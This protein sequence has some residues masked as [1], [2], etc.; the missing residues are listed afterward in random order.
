MKKFILL[1]L[2]GLLILPR[3]VSAQ[4]QSIFG[5]NQTSWFMHYWAFTPEDAYCKPDSMWIV[6]GQDTLIQNKAFKPLMD[7]FSFQQSPSLSGY[8]SEDTTSGEVWFRGLNDTVTHKIMD[9]RLTVNDSFYVGYGAFGMKA[10]AVDSIYYLNSRKHIQLDFDYPLITNRGNQW[11]K[12]TMIEGVGVNIKG[13]Y[14]D[15]ENAILMNHW[16]DSSLVYTTPYDSVFYCD[17]ITSL[18][19]NRKEMKS[20]ELFPNPMQTTTNISL[21]GISAQ[22]IELYDIRGRKI[23]SFPKTARELDFS[24]VKNGIY[25]IKVTTAKQG[26]LNKKIVVQH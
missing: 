7:Q 9:M 18:Q 22:K 15:L 3:S 1:A 17:T 20:F 24:D 11:A 6:H 5:E 13:V 14:I 12:Y 23:K 19:E 25:F 10:Y 26:A 21:N 8:V 2:I 4:Y 16:K